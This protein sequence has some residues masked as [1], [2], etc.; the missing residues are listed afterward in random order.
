MG[1]VDPNDN[2]LLD[3]LPVFDNISKALGEQNEAVAFVRKGIVGLA[4]R[5]TQERDLLAK[6]IGQL[7]T[8]EQTNKTLVDTVAG[9]VKSVEAIST[10]LGMPAAAPR[11]VTTHVS[12]VLPTRADATAVEDANKP[13]VNAGE[14]LEKSLNLA[15][16]QGNATRAEQLRQF[17]LHA[18]DGRVTEAHLQQIGVL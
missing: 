14:R 2:G 6:A 4:Q 15:M 18:Q 8:V 1:G 16:T 10:R 12:Q 13:A 3:P 17:L 9:L 11:G 5:S 7:S